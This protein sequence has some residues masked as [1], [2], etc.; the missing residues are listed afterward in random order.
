MSE[1]GKAIQMLLKQESE[2]KE[3]NASFKVNILP[4]LESLD[5]SGNSKSNLNSLFIYKIFPELKSLEKLTSINF[6]SNPLNKLGISL[7]SQVIKRNKDLKIISLNEV[8]LSGN[9]SYLTFQDNHHYNVL[10]LTNNNLN[11]DD[12][13]ILAAALLNNFVE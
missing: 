5:L 2:L 3:Q 4:D 13:K 12:I 8:K 6:S 7:I 11:D 10:N 9:M 1:E